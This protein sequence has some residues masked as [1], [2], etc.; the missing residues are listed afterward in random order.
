[1][2]LSIIREQVLMCIRS[3]A[4][5]FCLDGRQ[6]LFGAEVP[7][8]IFGQGIHRQERRV[9]TKLESICAECHGGGF[10]HTSI[11]AHATSC[12]DALVWKAN[13]PPT[14]VLREKFQAVIENVMS[15]PR[16]FTL[17]MPAGF[18][19]D[20][21]NSTYDGFDDSSFAKCAVS[22]FYSLLTFPVPWMLRTSG[23][24]VRPSFGA[25]GVATHREQLV[26]SGKSLGF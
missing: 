16:D 17:L 4:V 18:P 15:K 19:Y 23:D 6:S 9:I 21:M 2:I 12:F 25:P 14:V 13:L 1:M 10:D 22:Q 8:K 5:Y 3:C 11:I 7:K 26:C 20:E 24:G